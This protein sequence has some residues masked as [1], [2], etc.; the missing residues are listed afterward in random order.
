MVSLNI[1]GYIIYNLKKI[2]FTF[3]IGY[4]FKYYYSWYTRE[5]P[6]PGPIPLPL[7]GNLH[8]I[9]R[10]LGKEAI[11]LQKK[12]GDIF[13]VMFGSR[14]IIFIGRADLMEKICSSALKNNAFAHRSIPNP[15]LDEMG[16]SKSG[17]SFN[18]DLETWKFNRRILTHTI[19]SPIFLKENIFVVNRICDEIEKCWIN[20]L[21]HEEKI[22]F[23]KWSSYI[24][25]DIILSSITG[26]KSYSTAIYYNSLSNSVKSE[27]PEN[28]VNESIELIDSIYMFVSSFLFF[29]II[30]PII[31]HNFPFIKSIYKKYRDNND[32]LNSEFEKIINKRKREYENSPVDQPIEYNI[33]NLLITANTERD[34]NKISGID[35]GRPMKDVEIR[36]TLKELFSAGADTVSIDIIY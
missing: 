7:I 25:M 14:R 27:I 8:Q 31:R 5:N 28:V 29:Y 11:K 9:G 1:I 24:V 15:G 17:I 12:Y 35:Y 33:L 4:V 2:V 21:E 26:K 32:W 23:A 20:L 3:I 19:M 36:D 34:I 13:E 22:D 18:M 16:L 30:P 10:D 6:V